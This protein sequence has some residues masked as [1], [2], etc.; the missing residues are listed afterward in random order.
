[1]PIYLL[2]LIHLYLYERAT[3]LVCVACTQA[4][5]FVA[6]SYALVSV[7]YM[8]MLAYA[9]ILAHMPIRLHVY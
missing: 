8:H 6:Y 1:M 5:A 7:A 9:S 4:L 3:M 2:M